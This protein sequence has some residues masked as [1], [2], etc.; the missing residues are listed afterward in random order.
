MPFKPKPRDPDVDQ[1]I[2]AVL[3]A[4]GAVR[5]HAAE[6]LAKVEARAAA[7]QTALGKGA[8][9]DELAEQLGVTRERVRQMSKGA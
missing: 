3:D 7:I 9:F 4:D 6:R 2:Q 8:T 1:A 5:A